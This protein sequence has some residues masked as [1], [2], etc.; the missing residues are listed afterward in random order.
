MAKKQSSA[1]ALQQ[2]VTA[3]TAAMKFAYNADFE[4]F[5]E[6]YGGAPED[7]EDRR[8]YLLDK[9]KMMKEDLGYFI[10]QLDAAHRERFVELALQRHAKKG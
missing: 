2:A 6:V 1:G 5:V 8:S 4:E 3:V 10:G 7:A 9:Y